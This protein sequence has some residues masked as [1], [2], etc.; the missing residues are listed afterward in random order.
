MEAVYTLGPLS[1]AIDPSPDAFAFYKEGVFWDKTCSI[2]DL[3]HQVGGSC[4]HQLMPVCYSSLEAEASSSQAE[5]PRWPAA[6]L[7][8]CTDKVSQ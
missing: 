1:V 8:S 3:D 6:D 7:A 4:R 5:Q 2:N